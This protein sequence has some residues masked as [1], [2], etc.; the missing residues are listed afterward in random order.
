MFQPSEHAVRRYIERFAG[1]LSPAAAN[2]HLKHIARNARF[3]RPLPGHARLYGSGNVNLVVQDDVIL[4]V[5]RLTYRDGQWA[6]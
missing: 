2:V 1:N 5:Y 4:T 6:A 3:R